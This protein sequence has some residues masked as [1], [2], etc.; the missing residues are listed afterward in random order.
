MDALAQS[1][2][3]AWSQLAPLRLQLRAHC[4]SYPQTYRG[5]RWIILVD[6]LSGAQFRCPLD[7]YHFLCELD[8]ETSLQQA[9]QRALTRH[10][11]AL[12]DET[13]LATLVLQLAEND[14]LKGDVKGNPSQQQQKYWRTRQQAGWR[15]L[16]N[17]FALRFPLFDPDALLTRINPLGRLLF[18]PLAALLW[19]ALILAALIGASQSWPE[20]SSHWHSRF[21]DPGNLLWLWLLFPLLKALHEFGHAL[22]CKYWGAPV[23]EMGVMLLVFTPVPYVDASASATFA[24]K[25]R[26]MLVAAMGIL[27]ELTLAALALL[28]W[29]QLAP[30]LL[31]DLAFN[32]LVIGS[33]ST[34]LF[35]GNPL[36]RFDGYYVLSD[37]LEIPNLAGRAN[38]YLGYLF[39]TQ[40]LRLD[41]TPPATLESERPWLLGYALLAGLYRIFISLMIALWVA[42]KLFI[43]GVLLALW[44]LYSQLILP[45]Y[46]HTRALLVLAAAQ[47]KSRALVERLSA[48]L[49]ALT[50][51]FFL[52][53][54]QH[55][56]T[57]RG[58]LLLPEQATLRAASDGFVSAVMV[59]DGA[60]VAAGV[61]LVT[62]RNSQL[63]LDLETNRAQE[64]ELSAR[65]KD[66]LNQDPMAASLLKED[67]ANLLAEQQELLRQQQGLTLHSGTSGRLMLARAEDLPERFVKKGQVLGYVVNPQEL[68]VRVAVAQS[69]VDAIRQ[70]RIATQVRLASAP[71]F[72]LAAT[73]V[74]ELPAA[75]LQLPSKML[76]SQGG[77]DIAVDARDTEGRT[78]MQPVFQFDLSLANPIQTLYP[79]Q[80]AQV[81]FMHERAPLGVRWYRQLR[82]K[83]LE[84]FNS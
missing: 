66:A 28:A 76:G 13:A 78:A 39:K 57:V 63:Q 44:A 54:M 82:Q 43:V 74:Q 20:L 59:E 50:L 10:P 47:Q 21:M 34:L 58:I 30:G 45:C 62:L 42:G 55:S 75:T 68:R 22:A 35:N 72:P 2:A 51:L 16:L 71:Q 41:V 67:L 46:R 70:Q 5:Q 29:Q 79:G 18:H 65:Y 77:G 84:R 80:T 1:Q 7:A 40:L 53:P 27:V 61:A 33:L 3:S 14:L 4:Q 23:H 60:E 48:M 25:K 36:L 49:M 32:V 73:S 17:P 24:E 12:L 9:R 69:Q 6:R 11:E 15:K 31:R 38:Q 56:S 26:R 64:A 52:W 19:L 37:W 8:G 81:R 83:L